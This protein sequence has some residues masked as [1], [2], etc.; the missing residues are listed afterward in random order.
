TVGCI[1]ICSSTTSLGKMSVKKV[2]LNSGH[3]MPLLGLG[4]WQSPA[5]EVEAAVET[6]LD[7]GYRHIDTA[8]VYLNEEAVGVG[9]HQWLN[10]TGN[11]RSEVF[12]VTKLP[13]HGMSAEGVHKFLQKS[14]KAL[15]LDYVDLYLVHLPSKHDLDILAKRDDGQ[16]D[17]DEGTDL[18]AIWKEMEKLVDMG[19][20]K[21]IGVSNYSIKQIRKTCAI[22]KIKP[23]VNQVGESGV[24]CILQQRQMQEFCKTHNIFLTAYGPWGH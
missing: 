9:L 19:L 11:K 20:T 23:V 12:V 14:L 16:F 10:K 1:L 17:I 22:S 21:S 2:L 5:G 3:R 15:K 6:A 24:A 4:C 13:P 7:A 8:F 18:I